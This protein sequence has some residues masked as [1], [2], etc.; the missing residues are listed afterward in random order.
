MGSDR[1]KIFRGKGRANEDEKLGRETLEEKRP[2]VQ[3]K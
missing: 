1:G 2:T 3:K